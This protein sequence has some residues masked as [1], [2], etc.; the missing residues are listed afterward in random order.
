MPRDVVPIFAAP[1]AASAALSTSDLEAV[2]IE[3]IAY[4][5]SPPRHFI[6]V[7]RPDATGCGSYFCRSPRSFRSFVHFR[8]GGRPERG[9]RIH[10]FPA[11]PFY[12]RKPARCH[13]MWFL[14]LPLP[15]QL[16]QLCPF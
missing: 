3:E 1:R 11:A 16:P 13:G 10:G 4:T 7:S 14:F 9:D 5:D 6:F 15:A 2:R 12:L 8:S